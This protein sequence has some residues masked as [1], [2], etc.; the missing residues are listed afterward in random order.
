[1]SCLIGTGTRNINGLETASPDHLLTS[2][3][4]SP[5]THL[6]A[7]TASVTMGIGKMAGWA[8]CMLTTELPGHSAFTRAP[9]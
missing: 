8:E 7:P 1:M 6:L 9:H 4:E 3:G 5:T 2:L